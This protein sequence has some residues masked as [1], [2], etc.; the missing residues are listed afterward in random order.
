MGGKIDNRVQPSIILG[1]VCQI[2]LALVITSTPSWARLTKCWVSFAA[3]SGEQNFITNSEIREPLYVAQVLVY[4][5]KILSAKS[6]TVIKRTE[7]VQQR[8]TLLM[9]LDFNFLDRAV[10]LPS[11]KYVTVIQRTKPK[12]KVFPNLQ[13]KMVKSFKAAPHLCTLYSNYRVHSTLACFCSLEMIR[14]LIAQ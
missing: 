6:V 1:H 13:R 3:L 5:S 12:S 11:E 4:A 10:I 9:L 8:A 7:G 2:Q 14:T